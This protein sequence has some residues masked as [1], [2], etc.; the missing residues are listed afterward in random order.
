MSAAFHPELLALLEAVKDQP[1]DD[2]PRLVLADWL[3]EHGQSACERA[4]ATFIRLQ[5]RRARLVADSRDHR[6]VLAQPEYQDLKAEE[7]AL[8]RA[9]LDSWL[10]VWRQWMVRP[11]NEEWWF[12]RGLLRPWVV[13][14]EWLEH[15][16]QDAATWAWV[17]GLVLLELGVAG[18][19]KLAASGVL[20]WLNSLDL[21]PAGWTGPPH[22][23]F[24]PEG[25][26][27]LAASPYLRRICSLK[28][29]DCEI[30]PE[31]ARALAESPNLGRLTSLDFSQF[32]YTP[33]NDIGDEGVRALA[34]SVY[35]AGLTHLD[36]TEN[37]VTADGARALAESPHLSGLTCLNLSGAPIGPEGA[38]ALASSPF[39]C[40][41]TRL[42]VTLTT[43]PMHSAGIWARRRLHDAAGQEQLKQE[44]EDAKGVLRRRFGDAWRES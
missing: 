24:G 10:G 43:S 34:G 6:A 2:A 20:E 8:R 37:F 12:Q 40:R 11:D 9:H 25:A 7:E 39:L 14:V 36:L 21:G 29:M 26:R 32:D 13:G 44:V 28:F 1:D 41:L 16:P 23:A 35:L 18:M 27:V 17:D 38:R 33:G 30:G 31:G 5:C 19:E 42:H 4:R 22:P 15:V 3:E